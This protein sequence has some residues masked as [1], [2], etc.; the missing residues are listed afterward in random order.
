MAGPVQHPLPPSRASVAS[1]KHALSCPDGSHF[2]FTATNMHFVLLTSSKCL[3]LMNCI[4]ECCL[5]VQALCMQIR[6]LPVNR[7]T[8]VNL[9]QD[10]SK[11][12]SAGKDLSLLFD[13]FWKGAIF[14]CLTDSCL[15]ECKPANRIGPHGLYLKGQKLLKA[16]AQSELRR[17]L[18]GFRKYRRGTL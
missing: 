18:R 3:M 4:E 14:L 5:F 16:S 15:T 7:K 6:V 11:Q 9:C 13:I 2:I 1:K 12:Y 10:S 8:C 17:R